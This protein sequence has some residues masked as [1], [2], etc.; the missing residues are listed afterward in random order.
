MFRGGFAKA[1]ERPA[2]GVQQISSETNA[3][4]VLSVCWPVLTRFF[5]KHPDLAQERLV[6][7]ESKNGFIC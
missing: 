7:F 5:E 2:G 3:R 6:V 4:R 1:D